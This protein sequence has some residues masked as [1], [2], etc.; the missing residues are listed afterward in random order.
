MTKEQNQVKEFMTT[1]GQACPRS[2]IIPDAN[3]RVLRV[4]LLLEEVLE[5]AKASGVEIRDEGGFKISE[6]S[7]KLSPIGEVNIAE[8]ADALTDIDYVNLGAANAYGMD[9]EPFQTEVHSSNMTKLWSKE[10]VAQNNEGY[11][12]TPVGDKFLVKRS[13]GK[14]VKSPSY[15]PANLAPIVL[16]QRKVELKDSLPTI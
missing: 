16:E 3:I 13:D 2:P 4:K 9:L 5:L 14:V 15:R 8:V 7:I 1:F 11:M 12:V 10:E 6:N